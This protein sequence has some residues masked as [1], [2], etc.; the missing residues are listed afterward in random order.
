MQQQQQQQQQQQPPVANQMQNTASIA[1]GM[2]NMNLQPNPGSVQ[3]SLLCI[4]CD[5]I[6]S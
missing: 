1:T 3:V 6:F 2:Q 5:N 4:G